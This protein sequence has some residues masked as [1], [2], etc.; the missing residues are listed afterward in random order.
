MLYSPSTRCQSFLL[1]LMLVVTPVALLARPAT[2]GKA[3]CSGMCCRPHVRHVA[4][5]VPPTP[6]QAETNRSSHGEEMSCERGAAAH[7]AMCIVPSNTGIDYGVVAPLPPAILST[8]L[9]MAAPILFREA[10]PQLSGFSLM[11]FL[12][13]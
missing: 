9:L 5:S 10:L 6:S 4:D 7:L 1:A 13:P 3:Q 8:G 11:G 12:P 2:H